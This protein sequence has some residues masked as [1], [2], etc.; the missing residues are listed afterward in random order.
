[1]AEME[2]GGLRATEDHFRL[3]AESS[4]DMISRTDTRG[5]CTYASP[6][7]RDVLGYEPEEIVGTSLFELAHPDEATR[8]RALF[9]RAIATGELVGRPFATRMRHKNG[10]YV[11]IES[12]SKLLYDDGGRIVAVQA[13]GRDVS[14]RVA[15]QEALAESQ[16]S[17]RMLIDR[18]PNAVVVH[19]HKHVIHAN[20]SFARLIGYETA[21]SLVG[22]NVLDFVEAEQRAEIRSRLEAVHRVHT[23]MGEHRLIRADGGRVAVKVTA[24]PVVMDGELADMAIAEDLT[25]H[26]ALEAE[27]LNADRMAALGRLAA[28]VGHEI[29]NPL[30]YVRG[31]LDIVRAKLTALGPDVVPLLERLAIIEE[32]VERVRAIVADLRHFSAVHEGELG[33]VDP[34]RAIACAVATASHE[35]RMRA[36]VERELRADGHVRAEERRLVQVLVNLLVNAAQAIPEG[37]VD[38]NEIRVLT[39]DEEDGNTVSIEVWD[40][41]IGLPE[42][43][44]SRLFEP[45]F[46]TRGELAGTGLGLSTSHRII[47]SFGG[48]L[49]AAR[50]PDRQ[51]LPALAS[52]HDA[53]E[54]C[55]DRRSLR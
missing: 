43:D 50:R 14:E 10:S 16:K 29:N 6:A 4:R 30:A 13:T 49:H 1:M 17:F 35:I 52:A 23:G 21:E 8:N 22:R 39:R 51:H 25:E 47:T 2:N 28:A 44:V 15:A 48:S 46:T 53:R 9:E 27:L 7:C 45:F 20:P 11:W 12:T 26:K 24:L 3:L 38:E 33:A 32:G 31:N 55:R 18:M 19:R 5:V 54:S 41:G 40:T 34:A 36:R 37:H 42:G